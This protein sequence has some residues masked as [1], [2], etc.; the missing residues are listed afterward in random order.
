MGKSSSTKS[1]LEPEDSEDLLSAPI[2]MDNFH[3]FQNSFS[4]E[5]MSLGVGRCSGHSWTW[6]VVSVPGVWAGFGVPCGLQ[7]FLGARHGAGQDLVLMELGDGWKCPPPGTG[8]GFQPNLVFWDA[9]PEETIPSQL[10]HLL[11]TLLILRALSGSLS[12]Q[13]DPYQANPILILR[14]SI[15]GSSCG[16]QTC[17]SANVQTPPPQQSIALDPFNFQTSCF[18]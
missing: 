17:S 7:L 3:G 8:R 5:R 2:A 4:W 11:L 9:C 18:W 15:P 1:C 13:N 10:W 16:A 12:P 14:F 6:G